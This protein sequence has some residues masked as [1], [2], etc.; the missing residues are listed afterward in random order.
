M[1]HDDADIRLQM[2]RRSNHHKEKAMRRLNPTLG[3]IPDVP[4]TG[5]PSTSAPKLKG[6][7]TARL[8]SFKAQKEALMATV[9]QYCAEGK[10]DLPRE[11]ASVKKRH[12]QEETADN[13]WRNDDWH[14]KQVAFA[15]QDCNRCQNRLANPNNFS[16][17][18]KRTLAGEE[19]GQADSDGYTEPIRKET[20]NMLRSR[21][22]QELTSTANAQ[23]FRN[24][25]EW[26]LSL[27]SSFDESLSQTRLKPLGAT[28]VKSM[29]TLG[30]ERTMRGMRHPKVDPPRLNDAYTQPP[31]ENLR[32]NTP[33]YR[34][35]HDRDSSGVYAYARY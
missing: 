24:E 30:M 3:G 32:K 10:R 29:Q 12:Q 25:V 23:N 11:L 22:R 15:G 13:I 1:P 21:R 2:F 33:R 6:N 4:A 31:A 18:Y 19:E 27:N 5:R 9:S 28:P 7:S 8:A 35:E 17:V 14:G 20:K 16:G 26:R 34:Q